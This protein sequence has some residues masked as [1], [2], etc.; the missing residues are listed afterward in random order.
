[1]PDYK[2]VI[3]RLEAA[4]RQLHKVIGSVMVQHAT[5]NIRSGG[6]EGKPHPPRKAG[7][8][9]DAG[10][11]ILI[12]TGRGLRSVRFIVAPPYVNVVMEEHM[13][14]HNDG[15]TI[16]GTFNIR[17][18]ERNPRNRSRHRVR[19]HARKVNTKLPERPIIK[20]TAKLRA[21]LIKAGANLITN[22]FK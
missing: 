8:A 12:D 22:A 20:D 19:G 17:E 7:S 9:R 4:K 15:A 21:K 10:R 1:M 13:V 5:D 6:F 2:T 14:A 3:K 16:S 18:H 11:Q